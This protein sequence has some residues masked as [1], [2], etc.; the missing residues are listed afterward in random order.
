MFHLRPNRCHN[1]ETNNLANDIAQHPIFLY[2]VTGSGEN[3]VD[4]G[5]FSEYGP[6]KALEPSSFIRAYRESVSDVVKR[7]FAFLIFPLDGCAR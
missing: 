3:E 2:V 1:L 7:E 6:L 4:S 5:N